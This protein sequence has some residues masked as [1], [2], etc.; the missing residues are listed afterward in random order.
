ME[1]FT[2]AIGQIKPRL[3]D[4]KWNMDHHLEIAEGAS[5]RG[6]S[7]ILFPELSLTGY[8]I[9]DLNY[10]LALSPE[11]HYFSPLSDLSKKISIAV[12]AITI[13]ESFAIRNSLLY[14]EDG[15]L[16]HIHHKIYLPTYGMFEEQRYFL[17]GRKVK[18]FDTKFGRLGMLICEDLWHISLPYL[19]ALQGAKLILGSAASPTKLSGETYADG[20][21]MHSGYKVNSEQHKSFA[22]LLS[23]YIAFA[24][25]VGFEDGVNFWGGSELVSPHGEV[26][27]HGKLIEEETVFAEVDMNEVRRARLFARHFLD[28]DPGLVVKHLRE[29]GY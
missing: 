29:L 18:S 22:R 24:N 20:V 12:G 27:I 3:G 16:K 4:L 23:L 2:I 1:K 25:R 10:E 19:L 14:F 11:D 17:P 28:E 5:N 15:H 13:D 9:R 21:E 26:L 8:S 6:A 7:L